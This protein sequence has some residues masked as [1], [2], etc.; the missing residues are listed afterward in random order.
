MN[1]DRQPITSWVLEHGTGKTIELLRGQI[2]RIEQISGGQCV[3]FNCFNL[4]Y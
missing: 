1:T 2:L 3:D 4:H